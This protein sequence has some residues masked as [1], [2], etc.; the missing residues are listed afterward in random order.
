MSKDSVWNGSRKDFRLG[1]M[2]WF[3]LSRVYNHN[4][5]RNNEHL[6]EWDLTSAQFDV[7]IQVGISKEISQKELAQ[8][9]FVTK[10]N[11]TQLIGKMERLGW[12]QRKQDWKTKTISLTDKGKQLYSEVV[13]E[14]EDFQASQFYGLEQEEQK[15]LINLLK[16]VQKHMESLS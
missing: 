5:R 3:R 12:V 6:K 2:I 16:K 15:Q 13:P 8:K 11:I 7:L 9:L 1:L 10:G 4:I 14:Q